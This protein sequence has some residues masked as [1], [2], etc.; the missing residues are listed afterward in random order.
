MCC[1]CRLK[2]YIVLTFWAENQSFR[3]KS[4]KAQPIRTKFDIP[5][6]VKGWQCSG[7]FGLDRPIL[8]KMGAGT[9]TTE[10]EF[11]LCGNPHDL[12]ATLQLGT[13]E[14]SRFDSNLNRT[15]RFDSKVTGRFEI[16]NRLTCHVCCRTINN[17]RCSMTN[18][19]RFGIATGIY[20]EFN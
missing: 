1:H 10:C 16:S 20:I 6:H 7:N 13:C 14:V 15:S 3:N 5:G 2:A 12:S 18:F 17:T 8:G 11:F 4:G 19:N 9:S